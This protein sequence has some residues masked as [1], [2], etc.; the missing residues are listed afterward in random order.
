MAAAIALAVLTVGLYMRGSDYEF[1]SFD[2]FTYVTRNP[3]VLGGLSA[4]GVAWAFTTD[5]A[6]NWH[7]VTWLSH[8]L[9][10]EL[11]GLDAGGHHVT[12][13]VLH[14]LGVIALLLALVALTGAYWPSFFVVAL[15]ALHPLRVESVAWI[16]ERKD[17][18]AGLFAFAALWA[19]ARYVRRPDVG[20]YALVALALALS[21]M[22]KPT[23]VTLPFILL[24]LDI[25][26]LRRTEGDDARTLRQLTVEKLPL[27]GIVAASS[28]V[29]MLV[30]R[31]GGA[32][33]TIDQLGLE[34]RVANAF[35]GYGWYAWKFVWPTDLACFYPHPGYLDPET[36]S[37]T[38]AGPL[39]GL[40]F[41]VVGSGL[42]LA[43]RRRLPATSMGWRWFVGTL[44]PMIGLL[45]VG[46]QATA[47]RYTY[48]PLI[49][50]AVAAVWAVRSLA[51]CCRAG[52]LAAAILGVAVLG[53]LIPLTWRQI[54]TWK[55]SVT[56]YEH[57]LAV[58][59]RNYT[60]YN[61]Y[62]VVLEELDDL[63][64]AEHHYRKAL[65]IQPEFSAALIN[66]GK[67][68]HR[69]GELAEARAL[70]ERA[71]EIH[72]GAAEAHNNL[73]VLEMDEE[74]WGSALGHLERAVRSNPDHLDANR[75]LAR[76]HA[77]SGNWTSAVPYARKVVELL[78]QDP[79]AA[80]DLGAALFNTG[81]KAEARPWFE[82]ALELDPG[83]LEAA[84]ALSTIASE[85]G[86]TADAIATLK[87]TLE[88]N[89]QWADGFFELA[90]I[91]IGL[92]NWVP[93]IAW[94][95]QGLS[96]DD[97][98]AVWADQIARILQNCPDRSL[99]D[100]PA[101]IQWAHRAVELTAERDHRYLST[102]ASAYATA[103]DFDQ[104]TAWQTK[105]LDV[106]PI[107]E[108]TEMRK[109]LD[110]MR[111]NRPDSDG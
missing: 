88:A 104:A 51:S 102:L 71:L 18:L 2:D 23:A 21:L 40:A 100:L 79:Q 97:T 105:A 34:H 65:E 74:D 15:F 64:A 66:L 39:F 98:Q 53:A 95:K 3:A 108:K 75:N 111:A 19:Y 89:P 92:Q 59:D 57:A 30:Q 70:Y 52:S 33:R 109:R 87:Q 17:L 5:H 22:S 58:T 48:L 93:A 68:L 81:Q 85:E 54:G 106:A 14:G 36:Y 32:V 12:N 42:A 11:Y 43:L 72:P 41:L 69:Q 103:G 107:L 25:W 37:L 62:G 82:R 61:N 94:L 26:P 47:D 96:I 110:A 6:A 46:Q 84:Q 16:S 49:G 50:L 77:A 20:R 45:Q 31:A 27:F 8:M 86:R 10:V 80:Y 4:E 83:F 60:A 28:I 29:T 7:P 56:L 99:L 63:I 38:S 24:L 76:L 90:R 44:V 1:V 73:G 13:A 67:V 78:P 91:Q 35:E 9:D 55:S 101:A